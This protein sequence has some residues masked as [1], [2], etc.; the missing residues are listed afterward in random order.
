MCDQISSVF[1]SA[2]LELH[3]IGSVHP[4]R[5]VEAAAEVARSCIYSLGLTTKIHSWI[6]FMGLVVGIFYSTEV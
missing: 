4:F 2:Y 5:I 6:S 1:R 3:R